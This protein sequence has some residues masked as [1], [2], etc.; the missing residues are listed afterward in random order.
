MTI[1]RWY[2]FYSIKVGTGVNGTYV[3]TKRLVLQLEL[4]EKT[5]KYV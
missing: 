5:L 4:E 3:T 1:F 2:P